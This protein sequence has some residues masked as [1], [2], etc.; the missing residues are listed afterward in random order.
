MLL[1]IHHLWDCSIFEVIGNL[2]SYFAKVDGNLISKKHLRWVHIKVNREGK[3]ISTGITVGWARYGY[4]YHVW[5]EW[6]NCWLI[7]VG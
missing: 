2:C 6:G 1:P 4:E 7:E 5:T 3:E